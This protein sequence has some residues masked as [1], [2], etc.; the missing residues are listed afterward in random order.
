[1][2]KYLHLQMGNSVPSLY[3]IVVIVVVLCFQPE[4]SVKRKK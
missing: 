1:M 3:T 2:N 4:S